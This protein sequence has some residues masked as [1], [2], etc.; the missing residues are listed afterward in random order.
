[1]SPLRNHKRRHNFAD[2]PSEICDC[3]EDIEDTSH[4][5]I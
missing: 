4:F 1:M 2:T 3:D 5:F